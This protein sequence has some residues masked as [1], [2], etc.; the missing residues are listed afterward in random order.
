VLAVELFLVDDRLMV[1]ELAPRVHNSGHH[2]IDSC[3]ASQFDNHLRAI[4]G[5][6]LGPTTMHVPFAA[7]ANVIADGD[8]IRSLTE[9]ALPEGVA[10][11][12][13]GKVPRPGRKVGHVT[14]VGVD[15]EEALARADVVARLL[16]APEDETHEIT[17][18]PHA[19]GALPGGGTR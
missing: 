9:V 4:L 1:N 13:Y 7:M 10:V 14:A 15:G 12:V 8:T 5:W 17:V 6:P 3:V 19:S 18:A 11:H 2:T 16:S